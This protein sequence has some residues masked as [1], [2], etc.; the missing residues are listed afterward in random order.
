MKYISF[1]WLPVLIA[2]WLLVA[3]A[4]PASESEPGFE[5]WL[6]P[7]SPF[8]GWDQA[9]FLRET[10]A[11]GFRWMEEG[12]AARAAPLRGQV[13]DKAVL[14]AVVRFAE[15]APDQ[16]VASYYNRGDAETEISEADF[17]RLVR[18]LSATISSRVRRQPMPGNTGSRQ[19][20]VRDD[21]LVWQL[22]E[23]RFELTYSYSPPRRDRGE[24]VPFRAEYVRLTVRK[25]QPGDIP[26]SANTRVNVY[27]IRANLQRNPETGDVWIG[28]VPM[29]DQ[30]PKGY[31]A[32][33]TAE[34]TMR[35]FGQD[36]DQHQIAQIA[37]TTADGG[38]SFDQFR[39]ALQAIGRQYQYSFN[40]HIDWSFR[41]FQQ[42]LDHYNRVA[43]R[44]NQR[45]I[46]LQ[47]GGV[48][49]IAEVYKAMDAETLIASR[50]RRRA[51]FNRFEE[52][53]KRYVNGGAPLI[54]GVMLG[55]VPEKEIPQ[56][57]GGHLRLII[58]YN[59]KTRELL[60]SD[61]WGRGHELKRMSLEHAFAITTA[62]Y[63]LEP[64][65]LRL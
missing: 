52:R 4:T 37:N 10:R 62:L 11:N 60:Y 16:F 14:E 24:N 41:D 49:N 51:D 53:V 38:T 18:E 1:K 15:G 3:P 27:E 25:F 8:W 58:G 47:R 39:S 22:P 29:V 50:Q 40:A 43:K 9:T 5:N 7:I 36:V 28:N 17:Q 32:A 46:V 45:E 23:H 63:S 20:A 6:G 65:G 26:A 55:V 30:G 12:V 19:S 59:E 42:M 21:S 35:Y 2:G 13:F 56:A 44:N 64:R 48:V 54:W 34:R 57:S 31:C 33:A 61:S